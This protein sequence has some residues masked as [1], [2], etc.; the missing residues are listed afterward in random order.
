MFFSFVH[1]KLVGGKTESKFN[2]GGVC[3]PYPH[4]V[5]YFDHSDC[6]APLP[7]AVRHECRSPRLKS[8]LTISCCDL[9]RQDIG[10]SHINRVHLSP[11]F[12]ICKMGLIIM[13][14]Q[15]MHMIATAPTC[16]MARNT[17]KPKRCPMFPAVPLPV[18]EIRKRPKCALTDERKKETWC[19]HTMEYY[20]GLKKKEILPCAT[21]WV[22]LE[23]LS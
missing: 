1:N 15:D 12:F 22:N 14:Y 10:N 4:A 6:T 17:L 9:Q 20:S 3:L 13:A 5:P 16:N 18:A 7:T 21:T 23:E 19:I 11:R 8:A 2:A